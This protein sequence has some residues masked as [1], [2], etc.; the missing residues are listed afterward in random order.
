MIFRLNTRN[1]IELRLHG[2]I[3]H[4]LLLSF[5]IYR[6]LPASSLRRAFVFYLIAS[7]CIEDRALSFSF[8]SVGAVVLMWKTFLL[9]TG[10]NLTGFSL[11]FGLF[12]DFCAAVFPCSC[13]CCCSHTPLLFF[14]SVSLWFSW[15][16]VPPFDFEQGFY[17]GIKQTN[18]NL[19]WTFLYRGTLGSGNHTLLVSVKRQVG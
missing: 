10:N 15:T 18:K 14:F 7:L 19:T 13:W 5:L 6:L 12:P 16:L 17:D 4:I 8:V 2:I 3:I 1:Y 9:Y 11:Q